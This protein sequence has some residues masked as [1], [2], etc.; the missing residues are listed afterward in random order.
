MSVRTGGCVD[1]TGRVG[2]DA[3][4]NRRKAPDRDDAFILHDRYLQ[5]CGFDAR[6]KRRY[7]NS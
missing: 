6:A 4:F 7:V 2:A 1:V 3:K 5:W